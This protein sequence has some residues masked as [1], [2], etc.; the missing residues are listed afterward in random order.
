MGS[1]LDDEERH[2]PDYR[3][4]GEATVRCLYQLVLVFGTMMDSP[5]NDKERHSPDYRCTG[6]ASVQS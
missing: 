5:L 1:P 4:K 3:C 2:S 6:E